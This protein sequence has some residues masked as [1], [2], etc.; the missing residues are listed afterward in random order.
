MCEYV[1]Y[2]C[3]T[4]VVVEELRWYLVQAEG[5]PVMLGTEGTTTVSLVKRT[6]EVVNTQLQA[7]PLLKRTHR[8]VLQ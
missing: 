2:T 1:C 8:Y 5:V 6:E 7:V 4:L 3:A